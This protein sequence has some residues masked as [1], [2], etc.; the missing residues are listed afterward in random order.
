MSDCCEH[1]FFIKDVV[2]KT[3]DG[4]EECLKMGDEWVHLRL[5][6]TCG[7]VGCCDESKNKHASEHYHSVN[8]PL[9]RSFEPGEEWGWC[10]ADE[11][12]L[13]NVPGSLTEEWCGAPGITHGSNG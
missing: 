3:P 13:E 10:Y 4:C 11:L 1:L 9:V 8:H 12:L 7:H 2:P 6:A 5:C